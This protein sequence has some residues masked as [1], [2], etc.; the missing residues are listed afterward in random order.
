MS[1]QIEVGS[2]IM[3]RRLDGKVCADTVRGLFIQE[4]LLEPMARNQRRA[5][6][7]LTEHSWCFEEDI[8]TDEP[9]PTKS[10]KIKAMPDYDTPARQ[11]PAFRKVFYADSKGRIMRDA[12]DVFATRDQ[13]CVYWWMLAREGVVA[14]LGCGLDGDLSNAGF[15]GVGAKEPAELVASIDWAHEQYKAEG[16]AEAGDE[17]AWFSKAT[18]VFDTQRA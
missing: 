9:A 16:A 10:R 4:V 13:A 6:V 18:S 3:F 1:K 7:I 14:F 12:C 17:Y 2:K 11:V 8:V 5:A 15:H